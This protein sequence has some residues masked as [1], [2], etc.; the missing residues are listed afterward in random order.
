[1]EKSNKQLDVNLIIIKVN[2]DSGIDLK[3]EGR[4]RKEEIGRIEDK[5]GGRRKVETSR[6]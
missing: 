4:R 1:M 6:S 5:I 3:E 2:I